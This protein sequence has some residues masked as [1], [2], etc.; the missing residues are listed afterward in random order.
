MLSA[1][2]L[3]QRSSSLAKSLEIG[4]G[5]VASAK[6]APVNHTFFSRS[7]YEWLRKFDHLPQHRA[8]CIWPRFVHAFAAAF[9]VLA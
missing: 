4:A 3:Q 9:L 8:A 1:M 5:C 7:I 6:L 2:G